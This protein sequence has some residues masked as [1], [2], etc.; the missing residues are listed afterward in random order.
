M[1]CF[2]WVCVSILICWVDCELFVRRRRGNFSGAA[3]WN[4]CVF[5][6]LCLW[7]YWVI[8]WIELFLFVCVWDC[9]D[10][11]SYWCSWWMC[12]RSRSLNVSS[13]RSRVRWSGFWICFVVSLRN[14][15]LLCLWVFLC[16]SLCFVWV[17][18]F[19]L[20]FVCLKDEFRIWCSLN[21][22]SVRVR[23]CMVWCKMCMC[24]CICVWWW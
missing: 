18:W 10:L 11:W 2:V 9:I 20:F 16:M 17:K 21:R 22:A 15:L 14:L 8:W 12:Y 5:W 6:D 13:T 23:V 19:F 7:F 1:I 4:E 24:C 3:T